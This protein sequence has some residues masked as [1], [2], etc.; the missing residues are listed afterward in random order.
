MKYLK[1]FTDFASVIDALDDAS[2]GR[3]FVAMLNYAE[4]G[5]APALCGDE[6]FVWGY[7]QMQIDHTRER[8]EAICQRNIANGNK[9]VAQQNPLGSS[10]SQSMPSEPKQSKDK[11]K[12]KDNTFS[13]ENVSN[14]KRFKPPTVDEVRAYCQERNN[15]INPDR[16]VAYYAQQGWVLANGNPMK[17][18]KSAVRT[19]ELRETARG[20]DKYGAQNFEQKTI[21][22]NTLSNMIG[23]EECPF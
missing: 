14:R 23:E 6:R 2:K 12:E 8:Y 10:G 7:A 20:K 11:D 17:D 3:L 22:F 16:F 9:H 13:N 15:S 19:W 4:T 18:W 1:V 21:Q 5:V